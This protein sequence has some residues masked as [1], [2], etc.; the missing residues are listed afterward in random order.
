MNIGLIMKIEFDVDIDMANR[1]DFLRLVNHTPASIKQDDG[2]PVKHNTG[3]YFQN[4]PQFPLE[5]IS[6]IDYKT[7]QDQGWFKVDILNNSIYKN[8][9]DEAHLTQ[10]MHAEPLWELLQHEEVVQQLSHING[11]YQLVQQYQP[12]D[13]AQLAMLLALIRPGK[14]HLIGKSWDE[15]ADTVWDKPTDGS[16]YFKKSHSFAYAVSIVVQLNL[17]VEKLYGASA[18]SQ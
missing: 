1:E 17:L 14:R 18:D 12:K 2:T 8:V 15:I 11:H 6:A 3:I 9:V 5:Q 7:A 10:L 16:Y 4:I 13:V